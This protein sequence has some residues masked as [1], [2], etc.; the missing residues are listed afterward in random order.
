VLLKRYAHKQARQDIQ[1]SPYTRHIIA[2]NG[3]SSS[4][5]IV[6]LCCSNTGAGKFFVSASATILLV[7]YCTSLTMRSLTCWS[8]KCS[9]VSMCHAPFRLLGF[10]A[11]AVTAASPHTGA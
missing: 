11:I 7:L 3:A 5:N 2:E 1:L 4:F 9:H 6:A 8:T 10:S